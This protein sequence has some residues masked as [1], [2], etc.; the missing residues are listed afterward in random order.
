MPDQGRQ[1]GVSGAGETART[2]RTTRLEERGEDLAI[3]RDSETSALAGRDRARVDSG[4]DTPY[5]IPL[6]HIVVQDDSRMNT[7]TEPLTPTGVDALEEAARRIAQ[8]LHDEASQMLALAYLELNG[9]AQENPG[10]TAERIGGVIEHLDAVCAQIRGLS[11]ELHPGLLE[12][13]GLIP[14]LRTLAEGIGSRSGLPVSV[15]G[16]A[17][18]LPAAVDLGIYRVVQEALSNVVRHARASHAEVRLWTDES[19]VYL[20]IKDDGIGFQPKKTPDGRYVSGL[21]LVGIYERIELLGGVC[22]I[23]SGDR[24]GMELRVGIPI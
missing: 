12:R 24:N 8:N 6:K 4:S 5:S 18:S 14:A 3:G 15:S 23:L 7:P 22:H 2:D 9:L 19:H 11:H 10:E 13:Y 17:P 1:Q 20:A 16:E 21:G